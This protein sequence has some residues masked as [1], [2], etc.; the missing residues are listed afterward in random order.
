[1]NAIGLPAK[2]T[3]T[4]PPG[5]Q[6]RRATICYPFA[7]D[8][9]GGSHYSLLGLLKNLDTSRYRALIVPE[10]PD[11]RIAQIFSDFEHAQDPGRPRTAFVAGENFSMAKFLRTFTGLPARVRFLRANGVD[12]VHT[13][14]G[15]T[16]ASWALASW[17]A[18]IPLVW[19]HRADPDALGLRVLA[20]LVAHRVLTVSSFSLPKG[21]TWNA[22]RK[23]QVVFS[24]FDTS[25]TADRAAARA[26]VLAEAGLP[27]NALVLG[28]FGSFI[29]RKRP[30]LFVDVIAKLRTRLDRPVHGLLFG[31]AIVP[32][33]DAA[34]RDH[35]RKREMEG[36]V[37]IMGFQTPGHEWIAGCDQLVVPAVRE[38]LGRTLVEA[39]LVRTP[40]VATR[41]GGNEE[42]LADGMGVLVEPESAIALAD[43][44]VSVLNNPEETTH[45][46]ERAAV[47]ARDRFGE[48][49][50]STAVMQ[51][52]DE[53][54]GLERA[55]T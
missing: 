24:P 34:L 15:R 2:P 1:M 46:V 31:E 16:H 6:D 20:P 28:Y 38:P 49:R 5:T 10:E 51:V 14:D 30:F 32:E 39:M 12:I 45:M 19:H 36:A 48:T 18:R 29:E 11:G 50:H 42:A 9:V 27:E 47:T 26:K 21:G 23:A 54:L 25:V 13:N 55:A 40:V 7:G 22:S 52:Y 3:R 43:G 44:V 35:I 37:R 17:L 53:L 41:S 33:M 4:R 8:S